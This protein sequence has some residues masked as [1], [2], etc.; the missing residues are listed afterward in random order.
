M[1]ADLLQGF[2][3]RDLLIEPGK[4]RVTSRQGS[5][6][7][8]PKATEVLLCLARRPGDLVTHDELLEC[9]WGEHQGSREALSHAVSEVRHALGDH[10]DD[11][12]YIQTLL[13]RLPNYYQRGAQCV[14]LL[15]FHP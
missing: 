9:A 12:E 1:N 7:L 4:G 11:P 8:P 5:E 15:H 13:P 6:H 2:Y 10:K 3:L 14:A